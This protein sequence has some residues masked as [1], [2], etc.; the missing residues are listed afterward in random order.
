MDIKIRYATALAMIA[1]EGQVRRGTHPYSI[2][3]VTLGMTALANGM[4]TD[5]IIAALLHDTIEDTWVTLEFLEG[6]S[7]ISEYSLELI[8]ALTRP[9]GMTAQKH[10]RSILASKNK[11][12][13]LLKL[14]DTEDNLF[15][16]DG[17]TWPNM[18]ASL[19]RYKGNK[20][21]LEKALKELS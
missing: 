12:L 3:P 21:K 4:S 7:W 14:L 17:D 11:D 18:V 6:L 10:I 1:H 9:E 15:V 2:H 20:V 5:C 16:A 13:L 8:K 19:T